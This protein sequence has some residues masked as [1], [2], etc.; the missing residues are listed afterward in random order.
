MSAAWK[1]ARIGDVC[2]IQSGV[3][4][5]K[6]YQ[7]VIAGEFPFYKVGDMNA[8]GNETTINVAN[9]YI[10]SDTQKKLGAKVLPKGSVIFPKVGGAIITNKKRITSRD[11]C[12]DNNVMGL[13]PKRGHIDSVYLWYFLESLSI[14]EWSNKSNPP[15]IRKSTVSEWPLR[16]PQMSEQKHIVAILDE[17]FAGIERA[18][19][20]TEKNLANAQE[21]FLGF[22]KRAFYVKQ[23]G[24]KRSEVGDF[25]GHCLGKMLDKKKNRGVLR[26][27][28]RNV[29]V[30]WFDV[31]TSD[32]LAMKI[33]DA[34]VD[35]YMVQ[36][37][38][39]LICEGGYPGRA[40]I[41]ESDETMFFQ[42]AI[43]RVRC[44]DAA[45]GRWLM[46]FLYLAD[47]TG[48]LRS[49]FTGAGIQH[50]TGKSLK[51]F[52]VPLAPADQ[53]AKLTAQMDELRVDLD[54][55]ESTHK[56]KLAALRE[57][58]QSL[59]QKAFSGELTTDRAERELAVVMP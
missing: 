23:H 19:A 55:I 35:R 36:R 18:I 15:S 34:E 22:L 14:Y 24:W 42:K 3:G 51:R 9:N 59:L 54:R 5:P 38:D 43:H 52:I 4:F 8:P 56:R 58:K 21:L 29:N 11:C 48:Y 45:H 10:S 32:L 13:I 44:H 47:A 46:Y 40:A 33:E 53:A 41:W 30:R 27:Y 16:L 26:P 50:F 39:L 12:I 6:K 28:L 20:N 1:E 25:A 37:G 49:Y 7:G 2:E 31:D 57:L 17:A